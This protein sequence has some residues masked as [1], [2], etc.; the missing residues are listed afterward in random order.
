MLERSIAATFHLT[1]FHLT[2]LSVS[3]YDLRH[4]P[5]FTHISLTDYLQCE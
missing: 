1:S 4:E 2:S 5:N 3:H